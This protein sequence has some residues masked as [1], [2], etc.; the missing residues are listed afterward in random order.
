MTPDALVVGAGPAGLMAATEL[1]QSGAHVLIAEARPSIGRKFL[2]AGKSGLNLTREEAAPAFARAYTEGGDWLMPMIEAFGPA[3]VR[4]WARGL[5]IETF[6]GSSGRVFPKGLKASPL[7][8]AWAA[9]LDGL[10]ARTR[11]GWRW[12]GW[13]GD[14]AL[15]A[16][17]Q[18]PARVAAGVTVLALGGGSWARL[19]SN[20]QWRAILMA[21]G[22]PTMPFRPS[23][24]GFDCAWSPAMARHFGAPVKALRLTAGGDSRAGEIVVTA[25]GI[26]GGGVYALAH[27]LRAGAGLTLDLLPGRDL[28]DVE[29]RLGRPRRGA[30]LGNHLRKVLGLPP[31]K[32]ALL[33]EFAPGALGEDAA[34]ARAVKALIV[35]LRGAAPIDEAISTAG[36]LPRGAL[37]AGLMLRARPGVF[38]AGEMLDWDAPT[39]G[40]LLTACLATGLHAGRSAARWRAR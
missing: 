32:I 12:L 13:E 3:E 2:M 34:L 28:A 4:N 22:I 40:Y 33:R 17:A 25:R 11:T 30:S 1:A 18:G 15:F 36:G 24:C 7:L 10:G 9:R 19:G 16:T 29:A 20:G 23:N 21:E 27:L 31:V 35:P 38:A 37:D 39:G 8:R 6:V 5:G 14:A 26:E